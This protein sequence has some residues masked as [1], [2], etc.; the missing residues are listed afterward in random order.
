MFPDPALTLADQ[1]LGIV[2]IFL[3]TLA[4]E[5]CARRIGL[6][7]VAIWN[8]VRRF[9]RRFLALHAM[10]K[11]G[12]LPKARVRAVAT[13]FPSPLAGEQ[14]LAPGLDPG[15][16]GG[17]CSGTGVAAAHPSPQP[18]PSRGG[19][20]IDPSVASSLRPASMLPRGF[21]WLHRMLPL[22][23]GSL[24]SY[25]GP[26]LREHPEM[27]RFVAEC[28]Q[29]GRTLRPWCRM[30]G[31]KPP[32]YL[33]LPKRARAPRRRP[34]APPR[35]R[36]PRRRDYTNPRDEARAWMQWSAATHKPVDPRKMSPE[37]FGC[38]LHWPRDENC[39]PPEIGYGGRAFPP[40]PK[41]YKR[42]DWG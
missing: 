6:L 38:V 4:P 18:P 22:S 19:G 21:A 5:A 27:Q 23:A 28:P 33:A 20:V 42:P 31:V 15:G 9:E 16:R 7:S 1:I 34:A 11:A 17:G 8:R 25:L 14:R 41:D 37:A 24:A 2:A 39:P 29:V 3:K 13:S 40:L 35:L 32:D 30:A 36:Q 26:L 12:T 10:W